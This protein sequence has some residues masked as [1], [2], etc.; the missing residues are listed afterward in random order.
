VA[1]AY[2]NEVTGKVNAQYNKVEYYLQLK[3]T[4]D[5]LI[6]ANERLY[7]QLKIDYDLPDTSTK[8]VIDSIRVDSLI[9]F[10]KYN[11]LNAK[12]VYNSVAI[13]SNFIEI[14]R[15]INGDVKKEM[16]VVDAGNSVV[17]IVTDVSDKYAVVMSLLNKDSH[18]SGMLKNSKSAGTVIWDGKE[19]NRLELRDIP[20]SSK[21]IKGDSVITSGLTPAFPYGLLIGTIDEVIPDKS[22]NNYII[23]IKSAANFFSLQY[24]Y[25]IDNAEKE[26][27]N[28]LLDKAKKQNQ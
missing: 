5:S 14:A 22:T 4:N 15:G 27:M 10:K 21:I 2:V 24:V 25:A 19:P 20:K 13:Q 16:G 26:E 7:N 8:S 9:K 17:G 28:K 3:K 18:I 11:Y 12:V 23:K 1:S 6:K